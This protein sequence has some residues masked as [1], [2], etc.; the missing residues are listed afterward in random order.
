M[1]T[2]AKPGEQL[3]HTLNPHFGEWCAVLC[4]IEQFPA[5]TVYGSALLSHCLIG[6]GFG[7]GVRVGGLELA[8]GGCGSGAGV[9]G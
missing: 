7:E 5:D 4:A 1:L 9:G 3:K 6:A 2:S 8:A